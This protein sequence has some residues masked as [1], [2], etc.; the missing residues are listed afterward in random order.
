[1]LDCL[2]L[3]MA[4]GTSQFICASMFGTVA[5]ASLC[6]LVGQDTRLALGCY[7][8]ARL[9]PLQVWHLTCFRYGRLYCCWY[10]HLDSL[11]VWY[12]N[13]HQE[14]VPDRASGKCTRICC[15]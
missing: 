7:R 13:V 3:F 11:Q 5:G 14:C 15:R 6:G 2:R 1:M 12:S 8:Y 10:T 9:E 4:R